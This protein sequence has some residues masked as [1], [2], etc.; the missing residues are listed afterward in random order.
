MKK[1]RTLGHLSFYHN[2]ELKS[3]AAGGVQESEL[4]TSLAN[5]GITTQ[6]NSGSIYINQPGSAL[7]LQGTDLDGNTT[8]F[9]FAVS[10]SVLQLT[11][12]SSV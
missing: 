8:T 12:T 5:Q 6:V 4:K 9:A 11:P 10:G 2:I 7:Y 1:R 3:T